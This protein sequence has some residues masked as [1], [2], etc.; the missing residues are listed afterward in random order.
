VTGT[1]TGLGRALAEYLLFKQEIVVAMARTPSMLEE[2]T[3]Q[4][5]ADRLLILELD[6]NVPT[7]VMDAF[8]RARAAYGRIDVVV[9][10]AGYGSLGEVEIMDDAIARALFETNFWAATN[11]TREAVRFFC[12]ENPPGQG[13][14]LLQMSSPMGLAGMPAL[15]FYA[16]T[17]HA[18]EGLAESL[19]QELDPEWNIKVCSLAPGWFRTAGLE[20]A[21][22]ARAHPAYVG[23]DLPGT[24]LR[25]QWSSFAPSGDP[26]KVVEIFHRVAS[27][28]D[29]PL[30]IVSAK[31]AIAAME[32][33]LEE[34]RN[35]VETFRSWSDDLQVL[36]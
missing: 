1:S 21:L 28:S 29:P 2:L 12:E 16:A 33:K 22:L 9:N 36:E 6:V 7:D 18:L 31:D 17:K 8:V 15:G 10:N 5:S 27:L 35:I 4:Y 26:R 19:A 3:S 20:K 32:R 24:R 23:P 30:R 11:V 14:R 25:S 34:T 13:G